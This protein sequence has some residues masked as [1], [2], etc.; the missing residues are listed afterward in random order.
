VAVR[1]AAEQAQAGR[2]VAAVVL[3]A[4]LSS[5]ADVGQ[6]HYP[7]VPVRWLITDRFEAHSRVADVRAPVF[8]AHGDAD[9]I[10]PIRYGRKLFDA[11]SQPKEAWWVAGGGHED[12]PEHGLPAAVIGF[13]DRHVGIPCRGAGGQANE[14]RPQLTRTP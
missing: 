4:P 5:V 2:R 13:L 9:R 1:V 3:E 6:H 14:A 7:F 12:L 8:V 10:V 11:A